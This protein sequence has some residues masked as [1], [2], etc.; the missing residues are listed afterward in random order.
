MLVIRDEQMKVLNESLQRNYI[1]QVANLFAT[2]YPEKFAR[3]EQAVSFVEVNMPK[4]LSYGITSE[5]HV[6][7]FLN[8]VIRHGEDFES[9]AEY[10]WAVD[11]LKSDE[12][13]GEDRVEWLEARLERRKA[14]EAAFARAKP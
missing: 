3:P 5:L 4:A 14:V 9:R 8:F 1:Q 10:E 12:G 11:I 6:A 13:T 7:K 2:Q